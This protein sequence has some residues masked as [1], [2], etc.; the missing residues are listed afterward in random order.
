MLQEK[1]EAT[2]I[3]DNIHL[4]QLLHMMVHSW[5]PSIQI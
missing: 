4:H 3:G 5:N 1:L 2:P